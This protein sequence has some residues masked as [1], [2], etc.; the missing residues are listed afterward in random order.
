MFQYVGHLQ[1]PSRLGSSYSSLGVPFYT[2]PIVI[3]SD[4]HRYGRKGLFFPP[5]ASL[6]LS[7]EPQSWSLIEKLPRHCT[8]PSVNGL[9]MTIRNETR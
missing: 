9:H 2:M 6:C 7:A 4:H 3:E 1:Y 5:L 8:P